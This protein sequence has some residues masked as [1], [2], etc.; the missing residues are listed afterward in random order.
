MA[1]TWKQ[2]AIDRSGILSDLW[3][4]SMAYAGHL[5][6]WILFGCMCI[7]I[8]QILPGVHL[9]Q[10]LLN[11]VL[12]TQ[13]ITLDI[14]GFSLSSLAKHARDMG[15]EEAANK[16]KKTSTALITLMITTILLVTIGMLYPKA[17]PYTAM[18][19]NVLILVRVVMVVVYSHVI[20]ELRE[21]THASPTT[22]TLSPQPLPIED[23]TA[24]VLRQVAGQLDD[25]KATT[26]QD[27]T[28]MQEALTA[29]FQTALSEALNTTA[30]TTPNTPD[31]TA[32]SDLDGENG[33]RQQSRRPQILSYAERHPDATQAQIA[34][35]CGVS[36]RTV[37]RAL[38]NQEEDTQRKLK[39]VR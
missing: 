8:V 3:D 29:S 10:L 32:E 19:D 36:V 4:V 26:R 15:E 18:A 22:P 24:E 9:W 7:N 1:A 13:V 30:N 39:L 12:G 20:H 37:Q 34:E 6:R 38:S 27:M 14:A 21:V 23:I 28:S 35:A 33:T 2:A 11:I 31:T 5:A 25:M 17:A 16:A